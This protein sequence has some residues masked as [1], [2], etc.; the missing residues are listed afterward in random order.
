MGSK[1]K[2]YPYTG[3]LRGI[4]SWPP[5]E[6]GPGQVWL[7]RTYHIVWSVTNFLGGSA[8]VFEFESDELAPYPGGPGWAY[9]FHSPVIVD[10]EVAGYLRKVAPFGEW[11]FETTLAAFVNET[12]GDTFEPCFP[13]VH[14]RDPDTPDHTYDASAADFHLT[15]PVN[16]FFF[17]EN[18]IVFTPQP[19]P[20]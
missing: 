13:I 10:L 18:N 17:A 14:E 19:W 9:H 15:N 3:G 6:Y 4:T 1:G 2:Q 12:I 16:V 8:A 7:P 5:D 11:G 20:L